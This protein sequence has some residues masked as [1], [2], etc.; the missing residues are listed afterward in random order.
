[1]LGTEDENNTE[2]RLEDQDNINKFGRLNARLHECRNEIAVLK[3][4]YSTRR[5]TLAFVKVK[6]AL[7]YCT[8]CDYLRM[9]TSHSL[10]SSLSNCH[11][12]P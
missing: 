5:M 11:S 2:V 6:C 12:L 9:L 3:V 4:C 8:H 7:Q 10:H 1:M